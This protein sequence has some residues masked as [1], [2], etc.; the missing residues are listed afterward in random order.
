MLAT[1][2]RMSTLGPYRP[3]YEYRFNCHDK[4]KKSIEN[5]IKHVKCE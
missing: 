1:E 2:C 4:V 3:L 5:Y